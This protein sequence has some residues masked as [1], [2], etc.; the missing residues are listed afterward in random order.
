MS[1]VS[2]IT[3]HTIFQTKKWLCESVIK[4]QFCPYA[5][6]PYEQDV[7][8]YEVYL[9]TDMV[10]LLEQLARCCIQLDNNTPSELETTLLIIAERAFLS[11]FYDY[12]DVLDAANA[13]LQKPQT[14]ARR[15]SD[16]FIDAHGENVP[17]CWSDNYQI[18]SFHPDYVFEGAGQNDRENYTNRS[19]YPIFH[20]LRNSSIDHVRMTDER[21]AKLVD[22]NMQC[23]REMSA[24]EF[25]Q[26]TCLRDAAN[27]C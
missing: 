4:H 23:L 21:A 27:E 25:H 7:V 6:L 20:V 1:S 18:A 16:E 10:A 11:D 8:A 24:A 26:L 22:R 3:E 9:G 12:L 14:F 17:T 5:K 2:S 19:P 13:L 15:F